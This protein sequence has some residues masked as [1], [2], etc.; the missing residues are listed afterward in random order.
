MDH[1]KSSPVGPG[2][3]NGETA[4]DHC[5]EL[6]TVTATVK[7]RQGRFRWTWGC[8]T[9][10]VD[11]PCFFSRTQRADFRRSDLRS[12]RIVRGAI[13]RAVRM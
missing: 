13:L 12:N 1:K 10:E 7:L 5:A 9:P 4:R 2:P 8:C 6:K 3:Q 11:Q